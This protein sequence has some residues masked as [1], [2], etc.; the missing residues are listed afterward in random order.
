MKTEQNGHVLET[1]SLQEYF[2][3]SQNATLNILYLN[4][5]RHSNSLLLLSV[6]SWT[7]MYTNQILD[8]NKNVPSCTENRIHMQIIISW[9]HLYLWLSFLLEIKSKLDTIFE[10]VQ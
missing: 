7:P 8:G 5:I 9:A 2:L 4:H 3:Q 1:E 6:P 10:M